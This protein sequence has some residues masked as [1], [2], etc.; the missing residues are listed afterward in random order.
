MSSSVAVL[1]MT[2]I[3]PTG[4]FSAWEAYGGLAERRSTLRS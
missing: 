3:I 1:F 4:P 2:I